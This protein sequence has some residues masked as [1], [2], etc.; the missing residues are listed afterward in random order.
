MNPE[1]DSLLFFYAADFSPG[2]HSFLSGQSLCSKSQIDPLGAVL[3]IEAVPDAGHLCDERV[4]INFV[5]DYALLFETAADNILV[6][7]VKLNQTCCS[8][9]L[10]E[11]VLLLFR[12]R[13]EPIGV[14]DED[15]DV[16][17]V[18]GHGQ[19]LLDLIER[20]GLDVGQGVLLAVNDALLQ[21]GKQFAER[22]HLDGRIQSMRELRADGK[23]INIGN[24]SAARWYI[25][26]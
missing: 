1:A 19:I 22:Y 11:D 6:V 20:R 14:A 21:S 9:L 13:V 16:V 17:H 4:L 24:T 15:A 26:K 12:Q 5:D 8:S 18:S 25:A 10:N 3:L 23:I 2:A 7:G